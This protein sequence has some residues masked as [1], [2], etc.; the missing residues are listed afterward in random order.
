MSD[1]VIKR[2]L[3]V[4]TDAAREATD[5]NGCV[6]PSMQDRAAAAIAAFLRALPVD[7]V[8]EADVSLAYLA[9]EVARAAGG[10]DE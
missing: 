8:A 5:R 9:K 1:D 4:A 10:G 3:E 7:W 6:P 2:A